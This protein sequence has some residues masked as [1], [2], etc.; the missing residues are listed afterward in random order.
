LKLDGTHQLLFRADVNVLGG[1]VNTVSRN[2]EA[3]VVTSK[4]TG[5]EVKADKTK[6]I[7]MSQDQNAG[8]SQCKN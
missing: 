2:T 3:L 8:Q 5:V 4:D 7:V 1:S 6:C